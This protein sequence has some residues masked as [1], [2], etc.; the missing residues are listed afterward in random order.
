MFDGGDRVLIQRTIDGLSSLSSLSSTFT[1][2]VGVLGKDVDIWTCRLEREATQGLPSV[3]PQRVDTEVKP[4][5]EVDGPEV[6]DFVDFSVIVSEEGGG[7]SERSTVM[8]NVKE[9]K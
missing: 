7:P 2:L 3:E 5:T 8:V 9:R 1:S 4:T 6:D